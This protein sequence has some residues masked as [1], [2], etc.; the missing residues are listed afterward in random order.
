MDQEE[1]SIYERKK[2]STKN[3]EEFYGADADQIYLY[4]LGRR[5]KNVH[6]CRFR[7]LYAYVHLVSK[8]GNLDWS[9]IGPN[10]LSPHFSRFLGTLFKPKKPGLSMNCQISQVDLGEIQS[11][12]PMVRQTLKKSNENLEWAGQHSWTETKRKGCS[13]GGRREETFSM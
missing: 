8:K 12:Q 2:V 11:K 7:M 6:T 5:R 4:R 3:L 9:E 1:Y 10:V 13:G